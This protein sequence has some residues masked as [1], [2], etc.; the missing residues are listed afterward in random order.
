MKRQHLVE[1]TTTLMFQYLVYQTA[2]SKLYHIVHMNLDSDGNNS[3]DPYDDSWV[4]H[5]H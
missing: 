4:N 3:E 2:L 1:R 5:G